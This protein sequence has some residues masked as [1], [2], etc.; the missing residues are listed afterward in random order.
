MLVSHSDADHCGGLAYLLS[1][2]STGRLM[3]PGS[4]AEQSQYMQGLAAAA[5]AKVSVDTIRGYD[6]LTGISP[7][8]GYVFGRTDSAGRGNEGSLVAMIQYGEHTFFFSGDMGPELEDTL[9]ARGLLVRCTVL[10]APH[11]GSRINS[12]PGI[13][14]VL[15]PELC[16]IPV[17]ERNRFGHPSP[18]VVAGYKRMG[19]RVFRTDQSGAV[20]VES[21]GRRYRVRTMIDEGM[22]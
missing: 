19:A 18:E 15:R 10:K 6:A 1:H 17:G 13:I 16:V 3:V 11:H 22:Q 14:R 5:A 4:Q 9:N 7:C 20:I 8:R 2:V 21:D 12:A